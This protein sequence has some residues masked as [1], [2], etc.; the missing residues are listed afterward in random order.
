MSPLYWRSNNYTSG[1][2]GQPKGVEVLHREIARLLF[3]I[4]Y[5]QLNSDQ[6]FLQMATMATISFDASTFELWEAL[7]H[8]ARC[9]LFP[10]QI[11]TSKD[12]SNV[13]KKHRISSL[14]LTGSLFNAV[15]DEA[16]ETLLGISQLLIGGEA[17]SVTHVRRALELLPNTQ[18]INGYGPTEST[19]FTCCYPIPKKI[20]NAIRSIPIGRPIGNTEVYLLDSCLQPVPIGTHGELY[21]GGDGLCQRVP[22]RD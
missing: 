22:Q 9:V 12:L 7:L 6:T 11:P 20:S 21:I 14:W 1:S 10:E 4:D 2:T 8:G 15:I 19:T 3:G 5:V 13:I 17:L 18:I 16:P